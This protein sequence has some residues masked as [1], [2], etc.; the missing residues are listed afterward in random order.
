M[1]TRPDASYK[2]LVFDGCLTTSRRIDKQKAVSEFKR[3]KVNCIS[4]SPPLLWHT[5][6]TRALRALCS[7]QAR[8]SLTMPTAACRR[9]TGTSQAVDARAGHKVRSVNSLSFSLVSSSA[10]LYTGHIV[11]IAFILFKTL[12][13]TL[14]LTARWCGYSLSGRPSRL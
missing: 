9:E 13:Y 5:S 7:T 6:T 4:P 8:S 10:V 12:Y 1:P 3:H 14:L 2:M 11:Y